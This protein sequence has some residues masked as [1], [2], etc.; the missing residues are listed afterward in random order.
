MPRAETLLILAAAGALTLAGAEFDGRTALEYAR[1]VVAFGPRP[2]GSEAN[3]RL[4]EYIRGELRACACQVSED[5]FTA[6]TPAG[7]VPMSNLIAR[8]PGT[9]GKAIAVTGHF[10]TKRIPGFLGANDG[11]SSTAILLEIARAAKGQPR[12]DDLV[13]VWFDGEEAVG[14]W[15]GSDSLYGS[16]H[17]AERWSAE[18]A[19]TRLKALINVDMTGGI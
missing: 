10:D 8:F 1:R 16:R 15:S 14:E 12:K 19:L 13:L 6:A 7:P 11:A 2:S 17:L 4:R 18:G 3:R 5:R 9:S